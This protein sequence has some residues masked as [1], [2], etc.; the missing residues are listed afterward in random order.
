MDRLYVTGDPY[1][2]E[3]VADLVS[4]LRER[5]CRSIHTAALAL[6]DAGITYRSVSQGEIDVDTCVLPLSEGQYAEARQ[7]FSPFPVHP[8][9]P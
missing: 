8:V 5:S 9:S 2:R 1:D 7:R 3:L 6:E 4:L